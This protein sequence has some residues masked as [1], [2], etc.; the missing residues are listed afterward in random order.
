M[1][2]LINS[3]F[4]GIFTI[5]IWIA[6]IAVVI[7]GSMMMS[8]SPLFAF[9]V[10]IGGLLIIILSAGLISL[11]IKMN[12]NIETIKYLLEN[13]IGSANVPDQ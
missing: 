1:L 3:A 7:G 8:T 10:W 9:L 13:N 5:I 12:E 4:K 2:D 11:Q 6:L